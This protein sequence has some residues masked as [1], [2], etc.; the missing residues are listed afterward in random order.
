M[1]N[2]ALALLVSE[3]NTYVQGVDEAPV[4]MGNIASIESNTAAG[5]TLFNDRIVLSLVNIEEESAYKNLPNTIRKPNG[6]VEY[7]N[8]PVYLNLYLLFAAN[9]LPAGTDTKYGMALARLSEVIKFIQRK[10]SY[11]LSNSPSF[12]PESPIEEIASLQLILELYT[13]TFE[14]INHLWGSLGGKQMP[15]VMYKARLIQLQD[16]QPT[17]SG[18]LIEEVSREEQ[19][20]T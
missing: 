6:M 7:A 11:T 16:I 17:G 13:L 10:N 5:N 8:P 4:V 9:F 3:L 15:F 14:Q 12:T 19:A 2:D 1:I 18:S 20:I